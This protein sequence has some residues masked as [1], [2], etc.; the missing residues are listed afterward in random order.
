MRNEQAILCLNV[1]SSSCKFSLYG[2]GDRL[3]VSGDVERIAS[4][5]GALR[6]R[7]EDG[8]TIAEKHQTYPN[9]R[10]AIDALVD[11]LSRLAV[12]EAAAVGHRIVHG[13]ANHV[14]PERVSRS[15]IDDL[16]RLIPFDELHMPGAIDGIEAVTD[17]IP[18]V[19][20][21]ACFDTAF[22]RHM[23]EIAERFALSRNLYGEGVRRYGFHGISYEYIMDVLGPERPSKIVIA[24]LGNGA[25]MAAV[26]DG[27]GIDT[28]MGLTPTGGF[29]MGTRSGDLDPGILLYLLKVK[30]MD[31][32]AIETLVDH[33][34]GLAGVSGISSDVKVLLEKRASEP[35]AALAIEMFCYQLRKQIGAYAAA[36]NG[37]DL[38]IFTAGIGERSAAIR[39]EV[40]AG[41]A[42]LGI[43]LDPERNA[44]NDGTI[45]S[46]ASRCVVRV[47]S[48]NE[49]LMIAR[50]TR[51][52]V[53]H[54]GNDKA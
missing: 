48:T 52:T 8:K 13:G 24:H 17:R 20:Q 26:R 10:K 47:I 39:A 22:H 54:E 4:D 45:S 51:K 29:M 27:I 50:H 16:K 44:A 35:A 23:P 14:V 15:L 1:G 49:N 53:F 41:L 3:L 34:A 32:A 12:P 31:A 30:G 6:V 28:T 9:P 7:G 19:P 38:L 43:E 18:N 46:T 5:G 25:S 37:L 36:L 33:R 2:R 21:V 42:H 11:E 40:C